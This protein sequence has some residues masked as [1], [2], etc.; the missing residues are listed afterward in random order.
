MGDSNLNYCNEIIT[1][2]KT[3]KKLVGSKKFSGLLIG[4]DFNFSSIKWNDENMGCNSM[5]H[6][7]Q[8]NVFL[9]CLQQN[10]LFQN[11]T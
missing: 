6:L 7:E 3:A 9:S 4:K 2:I 5:D 11:I 8:A 10:F 1:S